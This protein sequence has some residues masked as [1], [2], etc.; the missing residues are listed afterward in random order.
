MEKF[1][2]LYDDKKLREYSNNIRKFIYNIL[3]DLRD[4]ERNARLSENLFVREIELF[5]NIRTNIKTNFKKIRPDISEEEENLIKIYTCLKNIILNISSNKT[6]FECINSLV[7]GDE[8]KLYLLNIIFIL[9]NTL[10]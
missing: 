5:S 6:Q 7:N 10:L 8:K 3:N 2:D 4:R 9:Q 1:E